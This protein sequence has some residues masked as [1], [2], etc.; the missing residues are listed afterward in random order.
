VVRALAVLTVD[1]PD[2]QTVNVCNLVEL[3]PPDAEL[4]EVDMDG[5]AQ[6]CAQ[7]GRARRQVTQLLTVG[8]LDDFLD[9]FCG[10]G[11]S[12]EHLD[13]VCTHL[14]RDYPELVLFI[15][16]NKEGLVVVVENTAAFGPV[17]VQT[18]CLQEAITLLK[19][20]MI[21][22]KLLAVSLAHGGQRVV[23]SGEV[24]IKLFASLYD[25]LLDFEA[26]LA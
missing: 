4:G 12:R 21:L 20:E 10:A 9:F 5:G 18:Y 24:T 15:D 26:L 8:K 25:F 2:L 13:D 19:Q 3:I 11:K 22:D 1:A 14:H 7:V 23:L 6:C 16:P 17:T